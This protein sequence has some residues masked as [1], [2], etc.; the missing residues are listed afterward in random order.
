MKIKKSSFL[1]IGIIVLIMAMENFFYLIDSSA[2]NVPGV[3]NCDFIWLAFLIFF[4]GYSTLKWNII[5]KRINAHFKLII[6]LLMI[7]VIVSSVQCSVLTGQPIWYG[8]RPQRRYFFIL[9]LYYILRFFY[10]NHMI[11]DNLMQK[12]ILLIGIASVML[13]L[14]QVLIGENFI[15][16]HV[17]HNERYGSMRLYVDSIFCVIIGFIGLNNYLKYRTKKYLI[18][19]G[20]AFVYE[21]FVAKGRLELTALIISL[22]LGILL[23]KKHKAEKLIAIC[24]VIIFFTIFISTQ[25]F[26]EIMSGIELMTQGVR[27]NNTMYG[28]M[29]ARTN[30]SEQ[31]NRSMSTMIFGC[32]YPNDLYA[33]A[34][35]LAETADRMPLSDNGIFAF[36][37]VYG[38][39][40][41]IVVLACLFKMLR[42]AWRLYREQGEYTYIMYIVFNIVLSYNI[43]FWWIRPAW[44]AVTILLMCQMEHMLYDPKNEEI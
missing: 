4:L 44:T 15:F 21:L 17:M 39:A 32:G 2:L 25:Y 26:D 16:I 22:T 27:E 18:C 43:V 20:L 35:R 6:L 7:F 13:F 36:I 9:A 29:I 33:P 41:L 5:G 10:S 11:E 38:Y 40:G 19:V 42:M 30:Y 31:L 28:R 24:T 14:M 3:F 34:A 12:G 23:M 37:Y 1:T 8:L